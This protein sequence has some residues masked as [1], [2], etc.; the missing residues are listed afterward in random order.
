MVLMA[1]HFEEEPSRAALLLEGAAWCQLRGVPPQARRAAFQLVLAGLR[2][3][4][5]KQRRLAIHCYLQVGVG[6]CVGWGRAG[7]RDVWEGW[8]GG[9]ST[10]PARGVLWMPEGQGGLRVACG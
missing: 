9:V 1:A 3:N 10:S 8:G 6:G 5:A 4:N 7:A 2:Y